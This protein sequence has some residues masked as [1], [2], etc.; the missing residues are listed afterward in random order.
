ML[1]GYTSGNEQNFISYITITTTGND[2]DFGDL[3]S[4]KTALAGR[5]PSTP[6]VT[7]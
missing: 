7:G 2:A 4:A 5:A 6:S 3:T 1:G